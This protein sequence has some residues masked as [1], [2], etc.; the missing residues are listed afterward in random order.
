MTAWPQPRDGGLA[1]LVL[2]ATTLA[3]LRFRIGPLALIVLFVVGIELRAVQFGMGFSDV[4]NTIRAALDGV[5]HGGNPYAPGSERAPFPYGP[6]ALLWYAPLHDPRIQ[7]FAVS[8]VLLAVLALRGQPLG[9]ALWATTPLVVNLASD[10]SNDHTAALLLL[11]ALVV[12]ERMPRAGALLIGVAAGFKIYALAW[13]PPIFIWAGAGALLAG[14]AGAALVWLPAVLLWGAGNVIGA[15]QA[16]DAVHPSPYY[17]LG[18]ALLHLRIVLGRT[19]LDAFRLVAGALTAV[20]LS[21]L[22]RTHRA[23]VVAGIAI[24]MVTLYGGFWASPAYLVPPLLV[25]C[26]YIDLWLGPATA[27]IPWPTDPVGALTDAVDRLWPRVDAQRDPTR[28]AHP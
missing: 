24:Y 20:A 21:P 5:A 11:V 28:I 27:R 26:W 7:E 13:L 10:G 18:D 8:I 16:A 3:S 22:A 1:F 2:A 9:L 15:F 14:L 6:L 17:S 19:T 4:P 25:V 23:V 12:L